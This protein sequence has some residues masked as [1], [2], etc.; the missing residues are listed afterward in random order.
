MALEGIATD[1][2]TDLRGG[3][4]LRRRSQ[5]AIV[6]SAPRLAAAKL[7]YWLVANK[8]VA[9]IAIAMAV[10]A[11]DACWCAVL[12]SQYYSEIVV[13]AFSIAA[14]GAGARWTVAGS[15]AGPGKV[16]VQVGPVVSMAYGAMSLV[17]APGFYADGNIL[18]FVTMLY[19]GPAYLVGGLAL[20]AASHKI[21]PAKL[22]EP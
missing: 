4:A 17:S 21:R 8:S 12:G 16:L 3:P 6:R 19:M 1:R 14:F 22:A 10:I 7:T 2:L 15:A 20:L 11:F 18:C 9:T 5:P 13:D